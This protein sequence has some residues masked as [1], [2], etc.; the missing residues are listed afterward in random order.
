LGIVDKLIPE[1]LGGAHRNPDAM[2]ETLKREILSGFE[3]LEGIP[4]ESLIAQRSDKFARMG[5]YAATP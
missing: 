1:P 3:D 2:A 5:R 4:P